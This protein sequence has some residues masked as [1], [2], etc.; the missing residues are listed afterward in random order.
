VIQPVLDRGA[1][2]L[3]LLVA[4]T[5]CAKFINI[6]ESAT[7]IVVPE[8]NGMLPVVGFKEGVLLQISE[9]TNVYP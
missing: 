8:P 1:L 4:S 3:V 6:G 7:I 9:E 2:A 5:F